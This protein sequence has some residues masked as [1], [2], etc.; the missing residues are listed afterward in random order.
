MRT[1]LCLLNLEMYVKTWTRPHYLTRHGEILWEQGV[2]FWWAKAL[3][4][5]WWI[6]LPQSNY[7]HLEESCSLS[8]IEVPQ[9]W[10]KGCCLPSFSINWVWVG[11]LTASHWRA[12][13][14]LKTNCC[15]KRLSSQ[16]RMQHHQHWRWRHRFQW[17]SGQN[18][19]QIPDAHGFHQQWV[20]GRLLNLY[21]L[22]K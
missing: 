19:V 17:R 3:L 11:L 10:W 5:F 13:K 8:I 14:R 9:D 1:D 12:P 18:E 2:R 22:Q 21:R 20:R 15:L 6:S 16:W 4:L 7:L